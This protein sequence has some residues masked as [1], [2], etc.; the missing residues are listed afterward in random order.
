MSE[1]RLLPL[2]DSPPPER[3]DA[4][5]NRELLLDAAKALV[6]HCGARGVTMDA[7]ATAAGVGKGTVFRRFGDRNGLMTALVVRRAEALQEAFTSGP[8][9]LGPGA[10]P[11]HRLMAFL[12]AAVALIA[13]NVGLITAHQRAAAGAHADQ[14]VYLAWHRHVRDLVAA[15]RP[16]LDAE[17]IAHI[18]LSALSGDL[19]GRILRD[20]EADRLARSLR[21]LARSLVGGEELG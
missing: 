11:A 12:D 19:V 8:P 3:R 14:P 16:D 6:E 13:S 15:G 7:V 17:L 20:S 10:P 18:L 5:R 1:P 2:L 4:A 21:D 9:P